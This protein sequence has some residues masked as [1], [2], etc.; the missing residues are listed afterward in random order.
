MPHHSLQTVVVP[1]PQH[2]LSASAEFECRLLRS[3]IHRGM[4]QRLGFLFT[5]FPPCRHLPTPT[6]EFMW[7]PDSLLNCIILFILL[8]YCRHHKSW[9]PATVQLPKPQFHESCSLTSKNW[10]QLSAFSMLTLQFYGVHQPMSAGLLPRAWQPPALPSILG[11]RLTLLPFRPIQ[12]S[13]Y[14][15][16]YHNLEPG[17]SA[18]CNYTS[19][20]DYGTTAMCYTTVVSSI[21]HNTMMFHRFYSLPTSHCSVNVYAT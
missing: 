20:C 7:L 12:A 5:S 17:F 3:P 15:C 13:F 2:C 14:T 19:S 9:V 8:T 11:H 10:S 18:Y 1:K 4:P 21:T 16:T 6:P